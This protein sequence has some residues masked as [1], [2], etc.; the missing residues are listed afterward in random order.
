MSMP[1]GDAAHRMQEAEANLFAIELLAP[2]TL[3]TPYIRRL[4]DLE[5][6]L[7]ITSAFDIS[8]A[9]AARRYASLHTKRRCC[10]LRQGRVLL[11]R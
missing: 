10:R 6:V 1:S 4:P 8:K 7:A 3:M 9:A 2:A 11:V 5:N